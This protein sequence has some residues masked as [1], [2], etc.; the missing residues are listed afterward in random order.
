MN[1]FKLALARFFMGRRGMDQ[2]GMA[3]YITG[4]VLY[5]L[6]LILQAG[7]INLLAFVLWAYGIFRMFSK[8]LYKREAENRAFLNWFNPIKRKVMQAVTRFK[9]RRVYK[10]FRCPK[11][12]SWLKLPR[13]V[14]EKTI[15]CGKCGESFKKKA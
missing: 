3:I 1:K 7:L 9:N 15:T 10:Y 8:N 4:L 5:I 2:L 6:S 11:C 12:H 14:G 13:G